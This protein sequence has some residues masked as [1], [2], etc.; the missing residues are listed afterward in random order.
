MPPAE[1]TF[2]Q[3]CK[4]EFTTKNFERH[5]QS[6]TH[7]KCCEIPG[8]ADLDYKGRNNLNN[9]NYYANRKEILSSENMIEQW[10]GQF[11]CGDYDELYKL[12]MN[13]GFCE[14][15][16]VMFK[17]YTEKYCSIKQTQNY[18]RAF[19]QVVCLRCY[20]I[21]QELYENPNLSDFSDDGF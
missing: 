2:C 7:K 4:K 17:N 20:D 14:S 3:P 9:R 8:Y 15:C 12:F 16:H 18:L 13:C 10:K 5:L 11:Y 21:A 6:S 19:D 1:K